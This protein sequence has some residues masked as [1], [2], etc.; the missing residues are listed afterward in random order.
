MEDALLE[1]KNKAGNKDVIVFIHG[2]NNTFREAVRQMLLCSKEMTSEQ[3]SKVHFVVLSWPSQGHSAFHSGTDTYNALFHNNGIYYKDRHAALASIDPFAALLSKLIMEFKNRLHLMCHSMGCLV[4]WRA[5][6]ML[7]EKNPNAGKLQDLILIAGDTQ[8]RQV[9]KDMKK[10]KPYLSH[11]V[12][13]YCTTDVA[14]LASKYSS[15]HRRIGQTRTFHET[16]RP[17]FHAI[18]VRHMSKI[19]AFR[20]TY[21]HHKSIVKDI[22]QQVLDKIHDPKAR[23]LQDKKGSGHWQ[24]YGD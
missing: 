18:K 12:N 16:D 15:H 13:Y 10:L 20:H 22:M 5:V 21:F 6:R 1:L 24:F 9:Q 11:C 19:D 8:K 4:G 7:Y 3:L 17:V 14:L 23:K 2:Y